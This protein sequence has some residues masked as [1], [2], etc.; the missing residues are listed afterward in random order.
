MKLFSKQSKL[1]EFFLLAKIQLKNK[2]WRE[3]F[4]EEDA[5]IA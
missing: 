5:L 1:R 3:F 2:S 4:L